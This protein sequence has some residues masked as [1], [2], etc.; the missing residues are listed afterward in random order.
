MKRSLIFPCALCLVI[1]LLLGVLIPV[2]WTPDAKQPGASNIGTFPPI[3]TA[4]SANGAGSTSSA[5]E[6]ELD[7]TDN[8]ILLHT[9]Y[10]VNLALQK[11]DYAALSSYVHPELGVTFTAYSTVEP[12]S[13]LIFTAAQIKELPQDKT[14]YTWGMEDGRG[15]PIKMTMEQY[16]ARYVYDTDYTQ[17]T[18]IGVDRIITGGNALENLTEAYPQCRFVDFCLPSSDPVNNG[19][20]WSSLKL[21]F[22]PEHDKWYLVAIVHGEWTI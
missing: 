7:P 11:Q 6:S 13:D 22:Q 8:F 16:F 21:V 4:R 20:D 12:E 5:A 18:E 15:S 9:A 10:A 19:L 2:D 17:A 3:D 1:G 14:V